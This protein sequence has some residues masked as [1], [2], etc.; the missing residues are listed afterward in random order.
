VEWTEKFGA[1]ENKNESLNLDHS[2]FVYKSHHYKVFS[3]FGRNRDF[4]SLVDLRM[5]IQFANQ[6]CTSNEKF[7]NAKE[8]HTKHSS[9][10]PNKKI[11]PNRATAHFHPCWIMAATMTV[12]RRKRCKTW[13]FE[14]GISDRPIRHLICALPPLGLDQRLH[15]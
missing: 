3:G 8:F 7:G 11:E 2:G 4:R 15:V 1:L 5:G 12:L 6:N 10:N 14:N 9:Q 13:I